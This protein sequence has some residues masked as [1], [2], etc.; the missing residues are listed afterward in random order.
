MKKIAGILIENQLKGNL[1]KFSNIGIG[2]NIN[3]L[4]FNELKSTSVSK[5]IK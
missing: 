1:I 3:Q 2:I 4:K 5:R